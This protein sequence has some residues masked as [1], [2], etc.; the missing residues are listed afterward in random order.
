MIIRNQKIEPVSS[1]IAD[2]MCWFAGFRAANPDAT[3]PPGLNDLR[4]FNCDL[5]DELNKSRAEAA[6]SLRRADA[7]LERC[8]ISIDD[9]I[10]DHVRDAIQELTL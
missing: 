1:A 4:E 3:L 5:K 2:V 6:K 10:R 9:T 7:E 8:G